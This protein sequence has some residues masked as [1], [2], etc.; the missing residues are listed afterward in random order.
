M[1]S[2]RLQKK[3]GLTFA[4][5]AGSERLRQVINKAISEDEILGTIAT[6]LDRGWTNFKLYFMS[7]LPTENAEDIESIVNLVSKMQR[8]RRGSPPKIRVSVSTFIPKPHTP[9]QWVAQNS[10]EELRLKSEMLRQGLRSTRAHLSWENPEVSLLEATLSRGDRRMGQVIQHA[11]QLGCTFD[12]WSERFS[13]ENW[14]R[15]FDKAGLAP[16]FYAYRQRPLT[17]LLPWSHIDVG[18]SPAFLKQEYQRTFE[19]RETP[20]CS[21]FQCNACGLERWQATCQR[22]YEEQG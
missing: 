12:A 7:G 13:Y 17:E 16:S 2:L 15:A 8:V 4:P 10:Q 19:A 5:E 20:N 14:Q 18:V 11:W 1:E 3:A 22:K 6:A 21:Q 9:F